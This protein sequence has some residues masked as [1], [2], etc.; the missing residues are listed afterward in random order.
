MS[1]FTPFNKELPNF[2]AKKLSETITHTNF[3]KPLNN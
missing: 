2:Y 3:I 1:V